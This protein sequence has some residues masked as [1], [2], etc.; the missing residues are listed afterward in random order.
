MVEELVKHAAGLLTRVVESFPT[1]TLHDRQHAKNVRVLMER[2]LGP[3]LAK[4][5]Q[6]EAAMLIL[7]AYWHDIG[8]VYTPAELAAIPTE[9]K[10]G[11]FLAKYPDAY[12]AY[13]ENGDAPT[14]AVREWYCR[15]RHADRVRHMLAAI[16][17]EKLRWNGYNLREPLIKLCRSHNLDAT[18]VRGKEFDSI[19]FNDHCDLRF[20][21]ILLRLADILDFDASRSPRSVYD[22]LGLADRATPQRAVSDDEW[23]KHL[24]A[25]GFRFPESRKPNY[26]LTFGA[27]PARPAVEHAVRA[28]LDT[29]EEELQRCRV[30]LTF[31]NER[32]DVE[33]PAGIDRKVYGEGYVY[34]EFRFELDREAVLDLFMGEQLYPD[35]YVFARELLQNSFDAIRLRRELH[36][37]P[38]PG[39]EPRVDVT[40]WE[41][42]SGYLWVRFDDTGIGM[43]EEAVRGYFLTVGRSYYCSSAFRAELLRAGRGATEFV[44]ISRFGIGVL[45]CFLVGDEV[46]VSTLKL[47]DGGRLAEPVRLSIKRDD[48][49]FV[50]QKGPMAPAKMPHRRLRLEDGYRDRPGTS[51]AVRVDPRRVEVDLDTLIKR[52]DGFLLAPPVPVTANGARLARS[53]TDVVE[54]PW[55][56]EP[57]QV[58]TSTITIAESDL[59]YLGPLRLTALPL[60]LTAASPTPLL[61]GQLVAVVGSVPQRPGDDSFRDLLVGWPDAAVEAMPPDVRSLL[62]DCVR[63]YDVRLGY[64]N[65]TFSVRVVRQLDASAVDRALALADSRTTVDRRRL[66]ERAVNRAVDWFDDLATGRVGWDT[67]L[68]A[69]LSEHRGSTMTLDAVIRDSDAVRA[70][71]S[72]SEEWDSRSGWGHNG[73]LVPAPAALAGPGGSGSALRWRAERWLLIGVVALADG[74]RPSLDAARR[75]IVDLPFAVDSALHLAVR[76]ALA[77]SGAVLGPDLVFRLEVEPI[78]GLRRDA[79]LGEILDDPLVASGVWHD[80][81]VVRTPDGWRTVAALRDESARG[82]RPEVRVAGSSGRRMFYESLSDAL[83]DSELDVEL[84]DGADARTGNLVVRSSRRPAPPAAPRRFPPQFAVPYAGARE[85]LRLGYGKPKFPLNARHPLVTWFVA[86]ADMLSEELP[87]LFRQ[88]HRLLSEN[89]PDDKINAALDRV[90]ELRED[91]R[92]PDAAYLRGR[93]DETGWWSR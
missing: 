68:L 50:L 53:T 78:T 77:R 7:A 35:P 8:M 15:W 57:I 6:L 62:G 52:V 43:D 34:G 3:K 76:R 18:E 89:G 55:L 82:G 73:I 60:D 88:L 70:L 29:V 1:Y 85:L 32:Q 44:P 64:A 4:I 48:E 74:L 36:G 39:D 38:P 81:A 83:T 51:I 30:L 56:N 93:R 86:Y 84:P 42:G 61:R 87:A 22:H 75:K 24:S 17:D 66:A 40:C 54:R 72:R 21:A 37:E 47:L 12:V 91:L 31:C 45:S 92:P 27:H 69:V 46:E 79:A 2:L 28:F 26:L 49:F 5:S 41:D 71:A 63:G 9:H 16:P 58:D 19:F 20:C 11:E 13:R 65:G 59:P 14:P 23:S 67:F 33:L 25:G 80:E 90:A 10:F